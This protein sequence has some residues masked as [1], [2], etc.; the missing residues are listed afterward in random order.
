MLCYLVL[1]EVYPRD[2]D[3]SSTKES[4]D[5]FFTFIA[6]DRGDIREGLLDLLQDS[7]S[8]HKRFRM[9]LDQYC[10]IYRDYK[11][12]PVKTGFALHRK[13]KEMISDMELRLLEL[14]AVEAERLF[15]ESP[16]GQ[17][18]PDGRTYEAVG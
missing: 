17:R 11:E 16:R 14:P 15:H 13:K 10:Q 9:H 2:Y 6:Q 12:D 8:A 5:F 3:F 1:H 18:S 4:L 7:P